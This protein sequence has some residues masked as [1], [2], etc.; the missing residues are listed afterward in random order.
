MIGTPLI[1]TLM[2]GQGIFLAQINILQTQVEVGFNREGLHPLHV[3]A[4]FRAGVGFVQTFTAS[5]CFTFLEHFDQ[6][7]A[8]NQPGAGNPP[9]RLFRNRIT[10]DGNWAYPATHNWG[11]LELA[12][13]LVK[14]IFLVIFHAH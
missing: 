4:C 8:S 6:A 5:H 1:Q 13:S 3:G 9:E 10:G 7:V 12:L 11:C 14:T 2:V